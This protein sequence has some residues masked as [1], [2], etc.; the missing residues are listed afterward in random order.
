MFGM[1]LILGSISLIKWLD[2]VFLRRKLNWSWNHESCRSHFGLWRTAKKVLDCGFFLPN[3]FYDLYVFCKSCDNCKERGVW[4]AVAKCLWPLFRL[5]R[6]LTYGES[7]SLAYFHLFRVSFLL[8]SLLTMFWN[9]WKLKLPELT[10]LKLL[11]IL[12]GLTISADIEHQ[13]LSSTTAIHIFAIGLL[14]F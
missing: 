13:E 8:Y 12:L 11:Q 1:T 4:T 6:F 10:I 3:V 5:L 2:V 7:I 14:N 9:G